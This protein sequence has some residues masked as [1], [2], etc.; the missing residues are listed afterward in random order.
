MLCSLLETVLDYF[1][2]C[3]FSTGMGI[4]WRSDY[5]CF[6]SQFCLGFRSRGLIL[7]CPQKFPLRRESACTVGRL[8]WGLLCLVE[9][10]RSDT[11][12]PTLL[13]WRLEARVATGCFMNC[14]D[15]AGEAVLSSSRILMGTGPTNLPHA[16]YRELFSRGWRGQEFR[17]I[18]YLQPVL[19][20]W[21]Q[22]STQPLPSCVQ[23]L[24]LLYTRTETNLPNVSSV[25]SYYLSLY[26]IIRIIIS[27]VDWRTKR[28]A[29]MLTSHPRKIDK[30]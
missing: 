1:S 14:R 2:I 7:P 9:L 28:F 3:R 18:T 21:R 5:G 27:Y 6:V 16:R 13:M 23:G 8:P 29:I 4:I 10:P 25:A 30:W 11:V 15:P 12:P 17:L 26:T 24:T 22:E 19:R 20:S